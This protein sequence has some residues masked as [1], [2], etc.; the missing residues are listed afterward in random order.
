MNTPLIHIV[1]DDSELSESFRLLLET[2]GWE[3]RTYADGEQ[4]LRSADRNGPGCIVLDM[5][6]PGMTGLEVQAALEKEGCRLPI[7]FL[8]AHG[9]ISMAVQSV[10]HGAL[11]FLEKPVDPMS[12]VQKVSKAVALSLTRLSAEAEADSFRAKL[13][14]LTPREL[15]V[16][17][18]VVA[19]A[20]NKVAA[21]QLGL[22]VSTIK[23][24][25]A[26]AFAKL[27]VHSS[28]ELMKLVYANGGLDAQAEH[29]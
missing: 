18:A 8:S 28:A 22:E 7:I 9:T 15:E 29:L 19:G 25:R 14:K 21:K 13:A 24:H 1:D 5:R 17:K 4:F 11:D 16:I 23:M 6:M 10:Q 3:V 27:G 20:P 2:M 26:N 12:F